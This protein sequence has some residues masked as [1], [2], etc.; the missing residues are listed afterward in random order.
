MGI[1]GKL[2]GGT[3]GFAIGGPLGAIA[4]AAF[5]HAYDASN[6]EER[7]IGGQR[8]SYGEESQ[9]T[10]FVGAFSMLAKLARADGQIAKAEIESIEKFMLY[11]LNLDPQSRRVAMNIFHAAIDSPQSFND[12]AGQF[13]RQ[14][15]SQPQL[16]ELMIDILIRVGT[17]D[18]SLSQSEENL[19]L[20]AVGIFGLSTDQYNRIKS[21]YGQTDNHHYAVLKTDASASN[22][23]IKKQYRKL[24]SE[25]HPDKIASKGLPDE[26]TK[27]AND[28]FREIKEAYEAI[29]Q[30]RGFN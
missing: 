30:E 29:K 28:K 16:L 25:Y 4:G 8:L 5:G 17:A 20:S 14:F 22:D 12:F 3:I 11:D 27:F 23:E 21:K 18:G 9:V 6:I 13:H 7:G 15:R 24:V 1:L 10:F 2:I 26:F 19:I